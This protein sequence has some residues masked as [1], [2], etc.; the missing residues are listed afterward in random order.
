MSALRGWK[1]LSPTSPRS[2]STPSSTP[3]TRRCGAA[4]AS[5]VHSSRRRTGTARSVQNSRWL[6]DRLRQDHARLPAARR[7]RHPRRRSGLARRRQRRRRSAR[8]LLPHVAQ[9]RGGAWIAVDRVP[10]DLDRRVWFSGGSRGAHRSRH[11]HVGDRHRAAP[12]RARGVLLLLRSV[13]RVSQERL[14]RPRA[15]LNSLRGHS[16]VFLNHLACERGASKQ[17]GLGAIHQERGNGRQQP[18][19][20]RV[21]FECRAEQLFIE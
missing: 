9:A 1:S 15:G 10:R 3:P 17:A 19:I 14:W 7:P 13:R 18:L 16:E 12:L 4:A 11:R 2:P 21:C 20:G 5:T 6:R 8:L